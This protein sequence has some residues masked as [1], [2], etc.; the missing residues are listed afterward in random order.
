MI[1]YLMKHS[2]EDLIYVRDIIE[3]R[4]VK[5]V[6]DNARANRVFLGKGFSLWELC[7]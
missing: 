2:K 5:S 3:A 1:P 6:I 4:K 7:N